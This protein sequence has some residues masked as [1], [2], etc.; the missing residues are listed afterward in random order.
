M[1]NDIS[2]GVGIP[3][4]DPATAAPSYVSQRCF[5]QPCVLVV[6]DEEAIREV[7]TDLLQEHD[8]RVLTAEDG[9]AGIELYRAHAADVKLVLLDLTLPGMSGDEVFRRFKEIDPSVR[10]VL[11]SGYTCEEAT[12]KFPAS[13][14]AGF[15]QKPF[16]WTQFATTIVEY[17]GGPRQDM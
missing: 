10:V 8:L 5:P 3:F 11:T 15:V 16:Q 6:D 12:S 14:L 4:M 17:V 9:A 2:F 13:S 7:M 1:S